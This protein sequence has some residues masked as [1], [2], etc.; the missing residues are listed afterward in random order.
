MLVDMLKVLEDTNQ[1]HIIKRKKYKTVIML[2]KNFY[3]FYFGKPHITD[4]SKKKS[5][6]QEKKQNVNLHGS[7]Q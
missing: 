7:V 4:I 5:G 2:L 1:F 3:F 6:E